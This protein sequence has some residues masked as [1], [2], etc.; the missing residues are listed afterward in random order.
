MKFIAHAT[1]DQ[2]QASFATTT[3]YAPINL[4][5]SAIMDEKLRMTLPDMQSASQINADMA[6]WAA[7][8]DA[9]GERWYAWQAK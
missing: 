5:S 4:D 9:I 3:G 2:A 6:Y 1:S 7:N 8:R